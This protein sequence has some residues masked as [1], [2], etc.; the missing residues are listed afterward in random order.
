MVPPTDS[1]AYIRSSLNAAAHAGVLV[2]EHPAAS[3][4]KPRLLD[5]VRQAIRGRH[6]SPRT[7]RA[8]VDWIKRFILFHKKRHPLEM[9]EKEISSFLTDLA[10]RGKV[11][12][13][14]QS[15]ALSAILFLYREVLKQD[16][17]WIDDIIRAKAPKR[18]PLVMTREEVRAVMDNMTGTNW[19]MASLLYGAGL[20]LKECVQLR[21]KDVDLESHQIIVRA[22]KGSKDRITVLPAV[23]RPHLE[24]HLRAVWKQHQDDMK[25][26]AGWVELPF[27]LRRKYRN[28]ARSWSWQWIFPATRTYKDP[29]SGQR[30]RHHIH[31]TVL[32]RAVKEAVIRSGIHKPASCHTFR[33]SFA[34]HLMENGSDVRTIQELLGHADLST[35]MIYMHVLNRG[36][37]G[38]ISPA[39]RV[40]K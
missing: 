32:Q 34:T 8:Y 6:Y 1:T 3:G 20:R 33:H 38:V 12:P 11:S 24:K 15:Q 30:R 19:L 27:G 5:Q 40:L 7:E 36:P 26:G 14:T 37:G 29:E 35:T 22:G 31:E 39:D 13:S 28:A 2:Y 25:Q 17:P 18:V 10:V 9:A 21:V 4:Q 16:V 23:S